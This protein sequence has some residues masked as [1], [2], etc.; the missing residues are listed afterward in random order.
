[1]RMGK[2]YWWEPVH[3]VRF[4][5]LCWWLYNQQ[6]AD[7]L[8]TAVGEWALPSPCL[9]EGTWKNHGASPEPRRASHGSLPC[10]L[11]TFAPTP[12]ANKDHSTPGR[13]PGSASSGVGGSELRLQSNAEVHSVASRLSS[14][15]GQRFFSLFPPTFREGGRGF[16]H[17]FSSGSSRISVLW[18]GSL[19]SEPIVAGLPL[20][21]RHH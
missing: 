20:D 10:C 15:G 19:C 11:P 21:S 7:L 9:E 18:R 16:S 2:P 8:G 6:A 4:I 13:T 1:M 14:Q 17:F 12:R 3:P 5:G